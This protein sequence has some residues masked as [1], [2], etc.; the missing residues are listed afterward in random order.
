MQL[1][2]MRQLSATSVQLQLLSADG[3]GGYPG[4]L[5]ASVLYRLDD[6]RLTIVGCW[7]KCQQR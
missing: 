5:S 3:D 1:W 6:H 7:G 2:Q 4:N